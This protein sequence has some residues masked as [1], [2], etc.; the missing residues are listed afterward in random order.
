MV[1]KCLVHQYWK[2]PTSLILQ[3]AENMTQLAA[4][5]KVI[6]HKHEKDGEFLDIWTLYTNLFAQMGWLGLPDVSPPP[7]QLYTENTSWLITIFFALYDFLFLQSNQKLLIKRVSG[8]IFMAQC[9]LVNLYNTFLKAHVMLKP[10]SVSSGFL[11]RSLW[12]ESEGAKGL[13]QRWWVQ[14]LCTTYATLSFRWANELQG[15]TTHQGRVCLGAF[16]CWIQC[17]K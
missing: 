9:S 15:S 4:Y 1:D 13:P 8:L 16:R 17:L 6:F 11:G 3:R 14:V 2:K 5:E 12:E 10:W 7:H